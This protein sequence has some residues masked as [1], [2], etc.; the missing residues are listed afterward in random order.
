MVPYRLQ[1]GGMMWRAWP[2]TLTHAYTQTLTRF[3]DTHSYTDPRRGSPPLAMQMFWSS[4]KCV[5]LL[6]GL[7]ATA[8]HAAPNKAGRFAK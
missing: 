5:L 3:S 6:L 8:S 7:Y 1:D 2:I 4:G